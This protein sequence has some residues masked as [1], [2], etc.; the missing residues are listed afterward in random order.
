MSRKICY[1]HK[2]PRKR[3]SMSNEFFSIKIKKCKDD[4]RRSDGRVVVGGLMRIKFLVDR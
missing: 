2:T 4:A 1:A 3:A